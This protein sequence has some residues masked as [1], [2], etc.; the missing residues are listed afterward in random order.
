[1]LSGFAKFL[2]AFNS[3]HLSVSSFGRGWGQ[4]PCLEP[5]AHLLTPERDCWRCE[6]LHSTK[7]E[8]VCSSSFPG[9]LLPSPAL[10]GVRAGH[11]RTSVPLSASLCLPPPRSS[12]VCLPLRPPLVSGVCCAHSSLRKLV[13]FLLQNV[14]ASLFSPLY[15]C[16]SIS[17]IKVFFKRSTVWLFAHTEESGAEER[18]WV[19]KLWGAGE[20]ASGLYVGQLAWL[21]LGSPGMILL[22]YSDSPEES[23]LSGVWKSSC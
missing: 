10:S 6:L 5:S 2:S 1:M 23:V 14:S 8:M 3:T 7:P 15:I 11:T 17:H 22:N 18:E 20:V 13:F 21:F 9:P 4:I 12:V 19:R 16:F